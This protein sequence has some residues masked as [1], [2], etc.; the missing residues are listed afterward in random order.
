MKQLFPEV[1]RVRAFACLF[2]AELL[3]LLAVNIFN[4]YLVLRIFSLTGSNTAV[5]AMLLSFTVPTIF[6][7]ILAGV[8][9][10]RWN[11]KY[12]LFVT[13]V[14]RAGL[15]LFLAFFHNSVATLYI[16]SFF[17]AV[18][19]QFFIPAEVPMIPLVV[20]RKMLFSANALFGLGIFGAMLTSFMLLGPLLL[21]FG[22]TLTLVV[23]ALLLLTGAGFILLV[24]PRNAL[25][26]KGDLGKVR[27]AVYEEILFVLR[28]L[29]DTK[30]IH[31]A[32]IFL[33]LSWVIILIVS[34]LA[35]GYATSVLGIP[36]EDFPLRFATPAVIGVMAGALILVRQL[37]RIKKDK[38]ITTGLFLSGIAMLILPYGSKITS[39]AIIQN[40]NQYLPS[41]LDI[42]IFH[43]VVAIAFVLG[44][45]NA[46]VFVPA[47]TVL[48]EMTS[49]EIRGKVYGVLNTFVG[50]FSFI[51]LILVGSLSD[52]IG[53]SSVII[54]IGVCLLALGITRVIFAW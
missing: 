52:L 48:Q 16:I 53:V 35:P 47:N 6:L 3:T 22:N 41:F 18:V 36:L 19:T 8:Y 46:F 30:E 10:D 44:F 2:M 25:Q 11:K 7:G 17:F 34:S 45:A 4:F 27:S 21:F 31:H 51:P 20:D 49:D 54:G 28:L 33:T 38:L 12:V 39:R 50:I 15:L 24:K 9:V 26:K 1:L 23:L 37:A 40:I 14:L 42:N 29:K 5:S 32:L 13:N 43:L